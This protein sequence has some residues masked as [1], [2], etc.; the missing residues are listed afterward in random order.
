MAPYRPEPHRVA[1]ITS[2]L[3]QI[4]EI[5]PDS[6]VFRYPRRKR[7]GDSLPQGRRYINIVVFSEHMERLCT[8]LDGLEMWLD[9]ATDL[10]SEFYADGLQW[11]ASDRRD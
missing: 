8:E 5:D 3:A 6:E 2:Y 1:G 11:M 9:H 4:S 10:K 7:G